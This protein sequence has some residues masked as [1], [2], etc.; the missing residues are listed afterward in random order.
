MPKWACD[1][2]AGVFF[3]LTIIM[4]ASAS[5][6]G[7]NNSIRILVSSVSSNLRYATVINNH[8]VL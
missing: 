2:C 6:K 4:I 5:Y 7:K 8:I 3:T 1:V